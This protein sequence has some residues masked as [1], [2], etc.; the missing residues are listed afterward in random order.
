MVFLMK[1]LIF[2]WFMKFSS[3]VFDIEFVVRILGFYFEIWKYDYKLFENCEKIILLSVDI[4][5]KM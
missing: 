4:K 2:D 1:W 3:I 5:I